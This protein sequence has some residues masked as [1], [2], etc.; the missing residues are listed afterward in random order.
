MSS[1][2]TASVVHPTAL[3]IL[4]APSSAEHTVPGSTPP[5]PPQDT[6]SWSPQS[7]PPQ[8]TL[9]QCPQSVPSQDTLSGSLHWLHGHRAPICC[10]LEHRA[11]LEQDA[12]LLSAAVD[13]SVCG[14]NIS[15][16]PVMAPLFCLDLH[17]APVCPDSTHT[18]L[19]LSLSSPLS[20]CVCAYACVHA[21]V[22][23]CVCVC[24]CVCVC[25]V[26]ACV[27]TRGCMRASSLSSPLCLVRLLS[28]M[29]P[30]VTIP[31]ACSF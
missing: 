19:C 17:T 23:G 30:A 26:P 5:V 21:C 12:V 3:P 6:L 10:L 28:L 20:L 14:W 29:P 22:C 9:S 15:G 7:A 4:A 24:V 31:N 25:F 8:D 13:G 16:A 1:L 11:L 27:G 2:A 18:S